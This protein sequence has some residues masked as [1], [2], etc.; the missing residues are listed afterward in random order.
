MINI[1]YTKHDII[2][3]EYTVCVC[4]H[5]P[6]IYNT[7]L[8]QSSHMT[9]KRQQLNAWWRCLLEIERFCDKKLSVY[10]SQKNIIFVFVPFLSKLGFT[11]CI[12]LWTGVVTINV[13]ENCFPFNTHSVAD[14]GGGWG[15]AAAPT[16]M[17]QCSTDILDPHWKSWIH[18]CHSSTQVNRQK[19]QPSTGMLA[20]NTWVVD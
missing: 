4:Q 18:P 3:R 7:L 1:H 12:P 14:Q 5:R 9:S 17:F 16:R 15:R 11:L 13:E 2:Y 6:N 10:F 8:S 20:K 19:W